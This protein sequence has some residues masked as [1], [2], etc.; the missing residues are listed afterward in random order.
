VQKLESLPSEYEVLKLAR[1]DKG[2]STLTLETV[3]VNISPE[4]VIRWINKKGYQAYYIIEKADVNKRLIQENRAWLLRLAVTFF[5]ASNIMM[6]SIAIYAGAD[7]KWKGLFSQLSGLL[8]L[9]VLIYSAFPFYK[10]SLQSLKEGKF[11]ADVAIAIAFGWGSVLSYY[12]LIRGNDAFYFDSSASFL[13]LILFA[14]YILY[15]TQKGIESEL[16]PSL[17]FKSSPFYDIQRGDENLRVSFDQITEGD[18][19]KVLQG[20]MIPVDGILKT[21]R[22]EIDT[23]IFS[24]ESLPQSIFEQAKLKAGMLVRSPILTICT[25]ESFQNSELYKLFEGVLKNRQ[26]KTKAHTRAEVYSQ[27]LLTFVSVSSLI[28]LFWFGL[29]GDWNEGFFRALALF[30]IACP[31]ALAL[32]IPL[33]SI[34]VL[35]RAASLGIIAKTPLLFEKLKDVDTI[36]FDKTG[37]LTEGYLDFAGWS[38]ETPPVEILKIILSLEEKAHHPLAKSITKML[39]EQGVKPIAM[40]SWVE[41]AGEG[42]S[43]KIEG[44]QYQ[45]RRLDH[46]AKD[47]TQTGFT[48]FKNNLSVISLYFKD[49]LRSDARST[50]Q[51]LSDNNYQVKIFSGDRKAVVES[52]AGD[53]GLAPTACFAEMTPVEKSEKLKNTKVLMIGDGHND[54]LALS[55]AFASLAISGSAETSLQAADAYSQQAGLAGLPTLFLLSEFYQKLINQNIFLS[56]T[57]NTIAGLLAIF[58]YVNPLMAAVLMPINSLVVISATSLAR[59]S[60]DR[61]RKELKYAGGLKWKHST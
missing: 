31:C 45:I 6:F 57:Y 58:G 19:V 1:F 42:V 37:T 23:S 24:G 10:S 56:L 44:D 29:R 4:E 60:I 2:K 16:N 17:L 8:F 35:K 46:I 39:R 51:W 32:A 21:P 30:T 50:V 11:S 47:P 61:Q 49:Q 34:T 9:P 54:S 5:F 53:L 25:T 3:G 27:R 43:A 41:V 36:V 14:R 12:N 20:Q 38:K 40:E 52:I 55:S 22:G 13:F 15:K 28:L 26:V 48:L 18:L 7:Q 59:L 33:A